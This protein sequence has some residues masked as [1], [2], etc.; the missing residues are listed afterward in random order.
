MRDSFGIASIAHG[1]RCDATSRSIKKER[2]GAESA[3]V[4]NEQSNRVGASHVG[5]LPGLSYPNRRGRVF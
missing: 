5:S 1:A 2:L 4:E 3:L